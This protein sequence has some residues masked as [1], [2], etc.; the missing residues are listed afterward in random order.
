MN[1]GT[2]LAILGPFTG[3]INMNLSASSRGDY[4]IQFECLLKSPL[5]ALYLT[6]SHSISVFTII[7]LL[8]IYLLGSLG[9]HCL[10]H[11]ALHFSEVV[12]MIWAL[13]RWIMA[14]QHFNI[15]LELI[16][17]C[18]VDFIQ[19]TAKRRSYGVILTS[20]FS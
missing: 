10:Q 19:N 15:I 8:Y 12:C 4:K 9:Q 18:A 13:L 11:W 17:T 2:V 3:P 16:S 6:L 20:S 7:F 1:F 14:Y 5:F